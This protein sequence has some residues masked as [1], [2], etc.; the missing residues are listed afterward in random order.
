MGVNY[1]LNGSYET[2]GNTYPYRGFWRDD[3]ALGVAWSATAYSAGGE[4]LLRISGFMPSA[5]WKDLD[6]AL[7]VQRQIESAIANA[8]LASALKSNQSD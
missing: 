2:Q 5:S 8:F 6:P 7:Y 3:G 4:P 1:D